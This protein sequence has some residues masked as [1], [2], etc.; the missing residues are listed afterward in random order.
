M[1]IKNQST[2]QI[3]I[4]DEEGHIFRLEDTQEG[5]IRITVPEDRIMYR[6][7]EGNQN[8]DFVELVK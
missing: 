3:I 8:S 5:K 6:D 4:E 2:H 1:R 7:E